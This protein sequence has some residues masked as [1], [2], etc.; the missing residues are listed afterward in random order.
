MLPLIPL[1]PV[2]DATSGPKSRL[3]FLVGQIKVP[4][5]FDQMGAQQILQLFEGSGPEGD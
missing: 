4:E 1:L 2:E 5:D 3:G